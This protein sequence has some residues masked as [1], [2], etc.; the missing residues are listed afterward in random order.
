MRN[1]FIWK[2]YETLNGEESPAFR[3]PGVENAFSEGKKCALLYEQVYDAQRRLEERLGVEPY[4]RDVETI[5]TAL[6]DIQMELCYK[7]YCYGA[8]FGLR[9]ER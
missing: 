4:D 8:K 3:I 2:V 6:T 1:S 7:M 5:I 9:D